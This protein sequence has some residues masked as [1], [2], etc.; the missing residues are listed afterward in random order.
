MN[1]ITALEI[2]TNYPCGDILITATQHKETSKWFSQMYLMRNG[3]IHKLM[4]SYDK[5]EN[6][7]GWDTD[8]EAKDK[9]EEVAKMAFTHINE[10]GENKI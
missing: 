5:S 2:T 1:L 4:L 8:K 7:D 3:R 6:F 10:L 9:M